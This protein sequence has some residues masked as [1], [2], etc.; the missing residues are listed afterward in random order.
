MDYVIAATL[1]DLFH[2]MFDVMDMWAI[3][4]MLLTSVVGWIILLKGQ[5]RANER[6]LLGEAER[7]GELRKAVDNLSDRLT[8][9]KGDLGGR[10]GRVEK[11]LNGLLPGKI[12]K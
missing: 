11:A 12:E 4:L 8:E 5:N 7:M 2:S 6:H 1:N 10:I 3:G 9:V